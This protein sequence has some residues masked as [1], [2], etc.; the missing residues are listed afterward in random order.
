MRRIRRG[1]PRADGS[2]DPG[3]TRLTNVR[4]SVQPHTPR[5]EI[6]VTHITL[7]K[8]TPSKPSLEFYSDGSGEARRVT[9]ENFPFRIG[10]AETADLRV[11][12]AEVSREHA[13]IVERNGVWLVR[14]LGSTNGTQVNGKSITET[15]LSD[16]DIL[17]VAQTELTFIASP[18]SQFQRMVTQPIQSKKSAP[19][20]TSLAAEIAATRMMTEATLWQA[21]PVQLLSAVSLRHSVTEA[22]FAPTT[23]STKQQPLFDQPH[24]VGERYREL[25][26]LRALELATQRSDANRLFLAVAASEIESPHRLFSGLK[27]LLAHLPGGWELGITISLPT[28]VDILRITEAYREARDQGLLVA[29]DEFQGNGGQVM[30]L[31]SLLPDYLVL[32]SSMTKDL[33]STR[34]PLRRLESLL[35]AC[36]ELQIKP[37]LPRGDSGHAI[38]LCQEIGF[39]L[40]LQSANRRVPTPP[41]LELTHA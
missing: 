34:Q 9:I 27:Q 24:A 15:L 13:E 39:D 35:A 19:V 17:K 3:R 20:P 5:P 14:D 23:A 7:S 6:T 12:S 28:D 41:A 16:G 33:T 37:V 8:K 21:I 4:G 36:E 10:R 29:F 32:A 38:N 11:E 31:E 22:L 18:V 26:R 25:E 2:F 40:V 1:C 30:H